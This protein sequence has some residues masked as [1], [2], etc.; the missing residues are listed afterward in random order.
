VS[1]P[2]ILAYRHQAR[3]VG[4]PGP[5]ILRQMGMVTVMPA[6][7]RGAIPSLILST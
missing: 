1:I 4:A 6:A 2:A 3:T 7:R 5:R